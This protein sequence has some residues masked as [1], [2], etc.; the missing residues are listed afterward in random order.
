MP[1]K[2]KCLPNRRESMHLILA[3]YFDAQNYKIIR[4]KIITRIAV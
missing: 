4:Y 1:A 3:K 2:M